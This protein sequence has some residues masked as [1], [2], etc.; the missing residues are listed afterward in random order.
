MQALDSEFPVDN[1][2]LQMWMLLIAQR[3][4]LVS[5]FRFQRFCVLDMQL[6]EPITIYTSGGDLHSDHCS[7]ASQWNTAKRAVFAPS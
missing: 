1:R 4:Q 5:V 7:W 3:L 2:K 6:Q